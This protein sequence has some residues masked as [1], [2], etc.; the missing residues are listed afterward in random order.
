MG[1]LNTMISY[2][3]SARFHYPRVTPLNANQ[4]AGLYVLTWQR[5]GAQG[6]AASG[7]CSARRAA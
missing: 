3:F 7:A 1:L 4:A 6:V 2:S 5:A